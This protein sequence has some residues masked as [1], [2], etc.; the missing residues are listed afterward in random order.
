MRP[1][2]AKVF[3]RQA[4]SCRR[5]GS[6]FHGVLCD[7]F[8]RR[9]QPEHDF[10]RRIDAWSDESAHRD[11]LP[12]RAIGGLHALVRRG[13]PLAQLYPPNALDEE[14][15]W[16]AVTDT[17]REH[18]PFLT[19]FLDSPPQTN[20]VARSGILLGCALRLQQ[21]YRL[22]LTWWELGAS[23]GLNLGFPDYRYELGWGKGDV[24]IPTRWQGEAPTLA[25]LCIH[26]RA[27]CDITPLDP[28]VDRERLLAYIW[29]DQSERL[30]RTERALAQARHH[31]ERAAG[32]TWLAHQLAR[33]TDGTLRV[34]AHTIVWQY[35][36]PE[37]R[38]AIEAALLQSSGLVVRVAVEGDGDPDSAAITVHHYRHGER[39]PVGRADFH[40]RWVQ[41]Y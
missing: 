4:A 10:T 32:S 30:A 11:A 37:E 31:V 5:L 17:I 12:L 35:L 21:R 3:T 19:T 18:D 26:E 2:I 39:E 34:V 1:A 9:M 14:A 16:S 13:A 15:L 23:A 20:E 40:G 33:P 38:A 41:W 28:V 27:G 8:A 29:P 6:P 25:P 24:L 22:P 7:L 36:P